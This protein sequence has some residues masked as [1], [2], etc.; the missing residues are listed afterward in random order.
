MI[1]AYKQASLV[2]TCDNDDSLLTPCFLLFVVVVV[3]CTLSPLLLHCN[4][5]VIALASLRYLVY[6]STII[7]L[8]EILNT[9]QCL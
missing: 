7:N 6:S 8:S 5:H 3:A 2:I 9:H 4:L 1:G